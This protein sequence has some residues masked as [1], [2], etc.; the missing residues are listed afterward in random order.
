MDR[1]VLEKALAEERNTNTQ[2]I[3]SYCSIWLRGSH[4][5]HIL[6][7]WVAR[8]PRPTKQNRTAYN[9]SWGPPHSRPLIC[10]LCLEQQRLWKVVIA[11][12]NF[13]LKISFPVSYNVGW[14]LYIYFI[15][16]NKR[17]N[18]IYFA[19]NKINNLWQFTDHSQSFNFYEKRV[20]G[21]LPGFF[22]AA[23]VYGQYLF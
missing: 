23:H 19:H 7:L 20:W 9:Y 18:I 16:I 21:S 1:T 3:T 13:F 8:V 6:Y 5:D 11:I 17:L 2:G 10:L 14:S 12:D 15:N 4:N 22:S